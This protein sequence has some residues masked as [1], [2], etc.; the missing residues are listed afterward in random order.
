MEHSVSTA[1]DQ[2]VNLVDMVDMIKAL[3]PKSFDKQFS[4]VSDENILKAFK[5]AMQG[6]S[7]QRISV[8]MNKLREIHYCPSPAEFRAWCLGNNGFETASDKLHA[9]YKGK[10][11]A[12]ANIECWMGD[13]S[14][15]IT[16]AERE[17]YNRI[18]GMFNQIQWANNHEKAKYY[19]YEA[20]KDAYVEVVKEFVAQGI[21]QCISQEPVKIKAPERRIAKTVED[22]NPELEEKV[23]QVKNRVAKLCEK[24]LSQSEAF[25]LIMK[26]ELGLK[27]E[28]R[29]Y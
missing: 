28:T 20:F 21:S 4:G 13:S 19:A 5:F 18:Y 26:E 3:H 6:I 24:G 7:R 1:V 16:N 25:A 2:S 14:T 12:I 17:A 8:G 29:N 27:N 23:N 9:S 11:A 22:S 15:L 10:F